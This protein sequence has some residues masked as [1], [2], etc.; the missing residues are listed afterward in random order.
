MRDIDPILADGLT[1]QKG[2]AIIRVNTWTDQADYTANPND[3]DHVWTCINYEIG[4]TNARCTII[5]ANNYTL[6]DFTVFTIERGLSI[7]GTEYTVHS[8]L[9]FVRKYKENYG[10]ITLEGSSYPNQ[11]ISIAAG[12]GT[13]EEVIDAFCAAIGK[14]GR[15]KNESDAWLNYQFLPDGKQLS[16][17]KAEFFETL[18]KQ[19]YTILAYE[20]SPGSLVFYT[21][22]SYTRAAFLSLTWS[23]ELGLFCTAQLVS[24]NMTISD[25]GITWTQTESAEAN[26]W[27]SIAW[28]PELGLFCAVA[29][30]GTNRVMTSPDGENWTAQAAAE[31]NQWQSICWSPELDLFCAVANSGTNRVMTSPDGETWTAQAAAEA[32]QWKNI[33]WSPQLGLFCAVSLS[34]T[35]RVMTSPDGEAWTAQAAAEANQWFDVTWSPELGLFCA[36]AASGTNRV[37]T[38]PD[39]ETWTAQAASAAVVWYS[40][41]WSP[42]L[43][44]FCAVGGDPTTQIMTSPD[45]E[46]WTTQTT[47]AGEGNWNKVAWSPELGLF[48]AVAEDSIAGIYV[49]TSPDGETW[50][51]QTSI[52]DFNLDYQDGPASH[53]VRDQSEV[54]YLWRDEAGTIHTAGDTD[55]PQWNLGFM[56]STADPPATRQDPYYKIFLQKAPVRLDITDGDKIH[57]TPYWSI[58]PTKTI[59]AM[60]QVTEVFDTKKSPS[61]Y[62][63]IKSIILFNSTEGGAL[64]ST[65][66]RVAAYTPLVTTS[67]DNLLDETINNLQAFANAVDDLFEAFP[68]DGTEY[69][70]GDGLFHPLPTTVSMFLSSTNSDIGGYETLSHTRPTGAETSAAASIS[71]ADTVIEEFIHAAGEFDFISAQELHCH[72]HLAKTA[73]VKDA[74]AYVKAYHRT[75]GGTETLLATSEVSGNLTGSNTAYDFDLSIEDTDFAATDRFLIKVFASPNGSGTTPTVTLYF[76]GDTDSRV[77]VGTFLTPA[78]DHDSDYTAANGWQS[79]T[80]TWTRTGNHTFTVSGD[81]TA[82]YRKGTKVRY[83]D[84]GAYEYATIGSSSYSAPNTTVN[85]IPNS[86]YAMAAATIT[87]T[88]LSYIA[89]PEGFPSQFNYAITWTSAASPQPALGNGTLEG[90]WIPTSHS[91]ILVKA[92]LIFGSTTTPGTGSWNLSIPVAPVDTPGGIPAIESAAGNALHGGLRYALAAFVRPGD[93]RGIY[94]NATLGAGSPFVW[95]NTDVLNLSCEYE[96]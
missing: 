45:G 26:V 81:V 35:N 16:L 43:S 37:M 39:G 68:G 21:Q 46:I 78:H 56:L 89:N 36:V 77:E 66:E 54:H 23:P 4:N 73:G 60:M 10:R 49:M 27:Q 80:A 22:D 88:Y 48:C 5:T 70:G 69:L 59:D 1:N 55:K 96:Y 32:N 75:S 2:S 6:S 57:F 15:F 51:A 90:K 34:G 7:G 94:G 87:D 92:R 44:L 58:D 64:P 20:E 63:E 53:I 24:G 31:A 12:D 65:I 83:K 13:Y 95:A 17:N 72:I 11:K 79:I 42:E 19:K 41:A 91:T 82:T 33:T 30:N 67:F 52:A 86:D 74:T 8:G 50:T 93:M 62:Q 76:E 14:T 18:L 9:M 25:N 71:A 85:L 61:W 84:G 3:P 47:V 28:S 38:S 40:V 29:S